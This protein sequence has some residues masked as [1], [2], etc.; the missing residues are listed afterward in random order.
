MVRAIEMIKAA[1]PRLKMERPLNPDLQSSAVTVFCS[2]DYMPDAPHCRLNHWVPAWPADQLEEPQVWF[3]GCLRDA[4]Q[5]GER[6]V[7]A[8]E[9]RRPM[10]MDD[11]EMASL[12]SEIELQKQSTTKFIKMQQDLYHSHGLVAQIVGTDG[13]CG[14][15]SC[16]ALIKD[17]DPAKITYNEVQEFRQSLK[18]LWLGV[19]SD[20]SW[21]QV[22]MM[23]RH[24]L[25]GGEG[26]D[27]DKKSTG[28]EKQ[29]NDKDLPFTPEKVG[30]QKR[31]CPAGTLVTL[32]LPFGYWFCLDML[33]GI[34]VLVA[35]CKA[36]DAPKHFLVFGICAPQVH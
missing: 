12:N 26:A 7:A 35:G 4:Q 9:A 16:L 2:A 27:K 23:L 32:G 21:Q 36:K 15:Y 22:W 25:Y 34:L 18:T 5:D 10:C 3:Q 24:R 8:L 19:S 20:P 1:V 28:T 17:Q 13:N 6:R 29:K 33:A 14:V 11:V 31:L 30:G